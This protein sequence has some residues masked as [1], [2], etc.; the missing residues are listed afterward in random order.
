MAHTIMEAEKFPDLQLAS[1][2]PRKAGN[3]SYNLRTGEDQCL[4]SNRQAVKVLS[5]SNFLFL[6]SLALCKFSI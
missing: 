2:K 6:S 3:V 5:Y 4:S 1:W